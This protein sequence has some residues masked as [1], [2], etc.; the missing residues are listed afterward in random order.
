MT[1]HTPGPW[2]IEGNNVIIFPDGDNLYVL[3]GRQP[4]D[5]RAANTRLI[6]A[7]PELFQACRLALIE[8]RMVPHADVESN[9]IP[10]LV[11]AI[12]KARG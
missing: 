1:K 5:V 12:A 11:A 8:L 3:H 4:D 10:D 2:E 9:A 6:A 7:A